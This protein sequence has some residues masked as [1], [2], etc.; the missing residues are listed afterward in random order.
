MCSDTFKTIEGP[1]KSELK[2]KGSR[3]ICLA[4]PVSSV[5]DAKENLQQISAQYFD[6]S[7]NCFAYRIGIGPM[8][9]SRFNDDGEP[10]GSAGKPIL[11]GIE[12]H[13]LTNVMVIVTRYFGGTKLGVGGLVRAYNGVVAQT[14][15]QAEIKTKYLTATINVQF[16]YHYSNAVKIVIQKFSAE[17]RGS[18]YKDDVS[19]QVDVRMSRANEF[20]KDLIER[21]G[22]KIIADIKD[23]G[24]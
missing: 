7:H 19:L 13:D 1:F 10:P 6:A 8:M 14:L 11:Q 5:K 16:S 4:L 3:F 22:G 2:V 23:R 20:I 17:I 12:T 21:S 18:E 24:V 15:E 9:K